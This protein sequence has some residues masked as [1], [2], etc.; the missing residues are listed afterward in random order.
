MQVVYCMGQN[1]GLPLSPPTG[2]EHFESEQGPSSQYRTVAAG[3]PLRHDGCQSS[4]DAL[5]GSGTA[6]GLA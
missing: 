5:Q 2:R 3:Y 6:C 1:M 4:Y